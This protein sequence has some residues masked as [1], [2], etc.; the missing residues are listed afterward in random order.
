[1][2]L[3]QF[4]DQILALGP[5]GRIVEQGTFE[6]LNLKEGYVNGLLIQPTLETESFSSDKSS[7]TE[8]RSKTVGLP[9]APAIP[10]APVLNKQLGDSATYN[11]YIR[12]VGRFNGYLF[13]AILT[14]FTFLST[15]PCNACPLPSN[16]PLRRAIC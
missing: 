10:Q 3:L 5:G 7:Q 6:S 13:I 1:V 2:Q 14:V 11:Y 4:A 15:F 8:E 12:S 9:S 16:L